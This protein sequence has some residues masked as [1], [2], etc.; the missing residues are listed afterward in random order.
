MFISS[1]LPYRKAGQGRP[2]VFLGFI[3]TEDLCMWR[4]SDLGVI[5]LAQRL[6]IFSLILDTYSVLN[7]VLSVR[8]QGAYGSFPCLMELPDGA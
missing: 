7:T 3:N 6:G 1:L 5:C 4:R 2:Y 8:L